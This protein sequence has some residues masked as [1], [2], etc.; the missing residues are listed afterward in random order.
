MRRPSVAL[1]VETSNA[2]ARGILQGIID[3]QRTHDSWSIFLPEQ[4]RGAAA[5]EW[6]KRWNGDGVIARIETEGIAKAVRSI[7]VPVVDVS[8]ARRIEGI[9][10]VETDDAQVA[11]LAAEHLLERGFRQFAY[12][13]DPT[14]NWSRWRFEGFRDWLK[15]QGYEVHE[16]ESQGSYA[17]GYSWPKEKRRL[18]KWLESLPKPIG[19]MASYDIQAQQVLD[20]CREMEIHIPDQ[21]AVVGV[22]NDPILCNLAHPSLTSVIP[23]AVKAGYVASELLER[24]MKGE[25]VPTDAQLLP[26]LGIM[27]RQSTDVWAV[28]DEEIARAAKF[29]RDNAFKGITVADVLREI[30]MSRRILEKKFREATG[31]SPHD[32]IVSQRLAK[33]EQL[34]KE[35]DLSL[36]AIALRTGFEHPEYMNVVF[37]KH[38][39]EPPGKYRRKYRS[40]G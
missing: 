25:S 17:K 1:L 18:A 19:L 13:G 2:Y 31:K 9:P 34:L 38:F 40:G 20:T 10:W 29:I 8:A 15:K 12:C 28:D 27:T 14:F 26:P 39:K 6:L 22:D 5:P 32:A 23:D 11:R 21:V 37:R 30:P 4:E 36:E 7:G 24:M 3:Y 16:Y 35:T 33:V